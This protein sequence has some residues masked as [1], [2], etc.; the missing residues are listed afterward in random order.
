[1]RISSNLYELLPIYAQIADAEALLKLILERGIQVELDQI[2]YLLDN[3]HL[4]FDPTSLKSD[5]HLDWLSQFFGLT[6]TTNSKWIGI[7]LNPNW[8]N[9][10]KRSVIIE[11]P[12]YF[13]I[14]GTPE[15]VIKALN[16]WLQWP[17]PQVKFIY[18]LQTN[19]VGFGDSLV[20]EID[21]GIFARKRLGSG[22]YF[23]GALYKPSWIVEQILEDEEESD[24]LSIPVNSQIISQSRLA[25]RNIWLEL[26][27]DTVEIWNNI[28]RYID[29]LIIESFEIQAI[30]TPISWWVIDV[31]EVDNFPDSILRLDVICQDYIYRNIPGVKVIQENIVKWQFT[32]RPHSIDAIKQL[33]FSDDNNLITS[34]TTTAMREINPQVVVAIELN[35]AVAPKTGVRGILFTSGGS[36][37][38]AIAEGDLYA[39]ETE[40]QTSLAVE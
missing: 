25:E 10:Y 22:D 40:F 34:I 13:Q 31:E 12:Y 8:E 33:F 37:I 3:R 21:Q 36:L 32:F 23:P 24:E 4:I 30:V 1:M 9:D 26:F 27:P 20:P 17:E 11:A 2:K 14:K 19:W 15:G 16:I 35:I 28:A 7:G 38:A 5:S 39:G 29:R 18:P 6:R